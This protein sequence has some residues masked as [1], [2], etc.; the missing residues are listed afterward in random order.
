MNIGQAAEASGVTAK[1]IRYYESIGLI[2]AVARSESGYRRFDD[3]DVHKLRFLR[4]ARHLGFSVEQVRELLQLWQDCSRASADVKRIA[5]RHVSDLR[6][7]A[8]QLE[9]MANTLMALAENCRGDQRPECPIL[10]NLATE[11]DFASHQ[12]NVH[13]G[14]FGR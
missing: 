7:K 10:D 5:L 6:A 3:V 12:V 2:S 4:K 9:E 14:S 1:M 8:V 13:R 11:Q